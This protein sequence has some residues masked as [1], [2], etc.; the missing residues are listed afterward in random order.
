MKFVVTLLKSAFSCLLKIPF[1]PVTITWVTTIL[2]GHTYAWS[3]PKPL[4]TGDLMSQLTLDC[5]A[6][7]EALQSASAHLR[8]DLTLEALQTKVSKI[9]S[10]FAALAQTQPH[11]RSS[12][13]II[14]TKI[15]HETVAVCEK[16]LAQT[17]DWIKANS[18]KPA[19]QMAPKIDPNLWVK[20]LGFASLYTGIQSMHHALIEGRLS[21]KE[22]QKHLIEVSQLEPYRLA[23]LTPNYAVYAHVDFNQKV[24]QVLIQ[25]QK[26]AFY[27]AQGLLGQGYYR[28]N[29]TTEIALNQ[30]H[31]Q[32]L[33]FEKL[34]IK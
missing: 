22:A 28:L 19:T 26:G 12:R 29:G 23:Y 4:M 20:N 13:R 24:T 16:T 3:Q 5:S 11:Y 21:L 7:D 18:I 34:E 17:L 31:Q 30:Q 2:L 6:L 14:Q 33:V 1:K 25:R 8:R 15:F 32:Y 27:P 10:G 9:D